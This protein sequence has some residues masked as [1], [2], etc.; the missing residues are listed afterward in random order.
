ML[1]SRPSFSASRDGDAVVKDLVGEFGLSPT[2]FRKLD[3]PISSE[4]PVARIGQ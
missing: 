2:I 1:K 3:A 4:Q